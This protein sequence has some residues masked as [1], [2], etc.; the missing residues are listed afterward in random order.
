VDAN[1]E[2][3]CQSSAEFTATC[4]P[5]TVTLQCEASAS[6]SITAIVATVQKNFPA[7]ILAAQTQGKLA[8]DAATATAQAGVNVAGNLTSLGGKA[9]AC[10]TAAAQ[11][12]ASASVSVNVSVMASASASASA[13]S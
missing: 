13:G 4:S 9:L 2:A 12:T 8:L 10:A 5:P 11:A 7:L 3:S 6:A 1:C